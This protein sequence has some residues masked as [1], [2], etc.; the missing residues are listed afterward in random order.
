MAALA[1]MIRRLHLMILGL[2]TFSKDIK[3]MQATRAIRL[4][5]EDST[6]LAYS[7]DSEL[8]MRLIRH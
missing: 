8:K 7:G 5:F 3:D 4:S 2:G 6:A 1:F